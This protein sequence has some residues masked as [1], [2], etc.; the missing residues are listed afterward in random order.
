LTVTGTGRGQVQRIQA[1][2]LAVLTQV[3]DEVEAADHPVLTALLEKL[4]TGVTGDRYRQIPRRTDRRH[5]QQG[6]LPIAV[7][8][9]W[10]IPHVFIKAAVQAG[11]SPFVIVFSRAGIGTLVLLPFLAGCASLRRLISRWRPLLA[12]A[13]CDVAVPFV[14]IN[15]GELLLIAVSGRGVGLTV[16]GIRS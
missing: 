13:V 8:L 14:L 12:V 4:L 11:V 7:A 2:R 16:P 10:G 6:R 9:L 5:D 3:L 1:R 15:I